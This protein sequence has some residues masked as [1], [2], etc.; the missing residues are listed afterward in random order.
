MQAT[1]PKTNQDPAFVVSELDRESGVVVVEIKK[2]ILGPLANQ[3]KNT[4]NKRKG[5]SILRKLGHVLGESGDYLYDSNTPV[6]SFM[7]EP[8]Q[9]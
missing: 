1:E 6:P 3:L 4:S 5:A 2:G 9:S 7:N 8:N